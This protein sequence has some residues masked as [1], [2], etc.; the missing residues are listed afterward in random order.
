MLDAFASHLGVGRGLSEHTV[1]GYRADAQ[2][3]LAA[4]PPHPKDAEASDLRALDLQALRS[5]LA[6]LAGAGHARASIARRAAAAR[7]FTAWAKR[8]DRID[9]DPGP[10]LLAPKAASVVPQILSE[11]EV[12]ALLDVATT[13]ADDGDPVHVR[14]WAALELLYASGLR[15]GELVGLDLA[16]VDFSERLVR[17]LGKGG[18]ERMVPFGVPAARALQAWIE[19]RPELR[20]APSSDRNPTTRQQK[21]VPANDA[22][23]LGVRGG[24]VG[25]RQVRDVVHHLTALAGV[26]DLAPHGLRHTAAT[27]LLDH[28]SDLRSVQ[29]VLGHSSLQTTQ[30]YTHISSERLRSAFHQAHPRA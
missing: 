2:S 15:I 6:A 24:R 29:E 8:T 16:H 10:R 18:K 13:R 26:R 19:V 22:L 28:G 23:F 1:R 14:D 21:P 7:T 20:A 9:V 30:R 27:H 3:L 25:A 4:L 11:A 12:T 5:W 17:V